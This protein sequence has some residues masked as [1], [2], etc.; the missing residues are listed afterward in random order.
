MQ[1]KLHKL[2]LNRKNPL[3]GDCR[4]GKADGAE[5]SAGGL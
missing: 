4:V 3:K 2:G 5:W 1:V